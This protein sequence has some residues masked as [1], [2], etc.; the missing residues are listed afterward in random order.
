MKNTEIRIGNYIKRKGLLVQVDEQTF[1]DMKNN[2]DDYEPIPITKEWLFIFG[3]SE[4]G[5]TFNRDSIILSFDKNLSKWSVTL[6]HILV[7][8]ISSV[9]QLQNLYYALV[10]QE[11]NKI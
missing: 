10:K 9:H 4:E 11:L 3:F 8:F 1:W 5:N 2:P 7:G 6:I